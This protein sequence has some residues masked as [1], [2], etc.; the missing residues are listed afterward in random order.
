MQMLYCF[1]NNVHVDYAELLWEGL[2]YSLTYP[3]TLIPYLRFTKIIIDHYM[4]ENPDISRRVHDNYHRVE[5]DDLVKNIFNS[6]KNKEGT[7]MKIPDWMLMEEMKLTAHYQMYTVVFQFF[8][9]DNAPN[10]FSLRIH[11]CRICHKYPGRRYVD[12]RVNIFDMV[13]IDLFTMIVLNKMVLQLGYTC[14]YELLFY[15]Y[16]RPLSSLD[17]GLYPLTFEEEV[18]CLASLFRSFKLIEFYIEHGYTIVNSYQ[19]PPPQARAT[20]EDISQPNFVYDSVTR[21]CMPHGMLTP[22]TDQS[23][24]TYTQLSGVQGLETQYHV[25]PIIKSQFSAINLS[26]ISVEPPANQVIDEMELDGEAGFGDVTIWVAE[27]SSASALQVLRRLGSIFTSVY[28]AVQKLKKKVYKAGKRLLYVKRNK[29]ISLGKCASKVGIEV[30]QLSSKDCTWYFRAQ[31]KFEG[32][33][34][35]IV[36][37]PPCYSASKDFQDSPG[38]E[39]DTRSSQEYINDLEE[40][41]QARA[42]LAESKSSSASAPS[43]SSGKN[44]GLIAKTYDWDEEEVSSDDNEVT[45][46][47]ALMA[48][49]DEDRVSVSKES[50][51]NGE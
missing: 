30:Q 19:R 47:K 27:V 5:N 48:L 43:S 12:G 37:Q 7:G 22:S 17:E 50:A 8:T 31:F 35:S 42:L 23:I 38:D 16:V 32:D 33:N 13:D 28:A 15:N 6:G 25:L 24:I 41:Y 3:T 49:A 29:A 36:I 1:I 2:Y 44:K 40:E 10:M 46:V 18:H 21:R 9:I 26:F 14:E 45:K 34:T 4:T 39:E 20:I 51:I 11:H